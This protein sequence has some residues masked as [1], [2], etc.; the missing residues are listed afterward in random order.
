[1]NESRDLIGANVEQNLG[2]ID[3]FKTTSYAGVLESI[4][5]LSKSFEHSVLVGPDENL[6][7]RTR[8]CL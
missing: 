7:G 6:M 2:S 1:M 3:R 8:T 4:E 5:Q